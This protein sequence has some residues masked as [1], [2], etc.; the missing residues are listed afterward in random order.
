MSTNG[1]QQGG[2][3]PHVGVKMNCC[4]V[5]IYAYV[6]AQKE[7]FVGWCPKCARQ[8]RIPIVKEGGSTSRVFEAG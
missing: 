5:Y 8:V 4:N 2:P 3:R 7:A 1:N 6:N